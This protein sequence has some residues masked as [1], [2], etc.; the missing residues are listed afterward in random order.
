MRG[1]LLLLL[2]GCVRSC[3]GPVV[4]SSDTSVVAGEERNVLVLVLDGLRFDESFSD[5]YSSAADMETEDILPSIRS[6][7]LPAGAL[8]K[9]GYST[10][11][12]ITAPGHVDMIT[13]ARNAFGNYPNG[14]GEGAYLPDVPTLFEELRRQKGLGSDATLFASNAQLA[15]PGF[16]SM[17]PGYMGLGAEKIYYYTEDAAITDPQTLLELRTQLEEQ[18]PQLTFVNLHGIDRAG[19]FEAAN[20]YPD[21]AQALDEVLLNFWKWLQTVDG[22]GPNTVLVLTADHGRHR[23][24]REEDWRNHGD[25]CGGC[26]ELPMFLVG[27]GV[28]EGVIIE[29]QYTLTDLSRTLAYLLDIDQPYGEGV[30]ITEA[31]AEAPETDS[32]RTGAVL[33]A[34]ASGRTAWQQWQ[35]GVPRSVVE[36]DGEVVSGGDL[37][38]A[39]APVML[40]TGLGTVACWRELEMNPGADLMPWFGVCALDDGSGWKDMSFPE[41]LVWPL[42]SPSLMEGADG[43]VWMSMISNSGG[44]VGA[45]VFSAAQMWLMQYDDDANTWGQASIFD[46]NGAGM[47]FPTHAR[48]TRA[49]TQIFASFTTSNDGDIGRKSRRVDVVSY[50]PARPEAGW[51]KV[52]SMGPSSATEAVLDLTIDAD[53]LE[54]S[55]LASPDGTE[56][57]LGVVSYKVAGTTHVV[58]THSADGGRSWDEAVQLGDNGRVFP[59]LDPSWDDDGALVWA[60]KTDTDSVEICKSTIGGSARCTDTG[61][62]YI[63]GLA[64]DGADVVVSA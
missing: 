25:H 48:L 46:N 3:G 11:I 19:H 36:I 4:D 32:S 21:Q 39:E 34:A 33:P 62:A 56:L 1:I 28:A 55:A 51:G 23:L 35:S 9:P 8:I 63:M 47:V 44:T 50:E 37:F 60:Q 17:H 24:G 29:E 58:A 30:L 26:R 54:R 10:G 64:V 2:T 49:G 20:E 7:L 12:T 6:E 14:D 43:T 40:E 45:E 61:A 18:R 38:A 41:T 16:Q 31:L 15:L 52:L 27:P 13:G 59:H 53:R 5:G 22:Y 42:W 57:L